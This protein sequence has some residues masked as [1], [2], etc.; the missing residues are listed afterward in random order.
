M[1]NNVC[2]APPL[3]GSGEALA[4]AIWNRIKR[5]SIRQFF[6]LLRVFIS[7]PHYIFPTHKA[8]LETLHICDRKFGKAHHKHGR[9]NAFRHALW[10]III[11]KNCYKPG[12]NVQS[13]VNWAEKVTTLH[14]K[15]APNEPLE[16]AMDLHNNHIGLELFVNEQLYDESLEKAKEVL[17]KAVKNSLK[18]TAISDIENAKNQMVHIED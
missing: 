17:L 13:V 5:L 10:N 3:E 14:E 12:K 7:K 8:T 11:A 16:T 9:E 15:L 4:M 18:I 6:I 1:T 2:K